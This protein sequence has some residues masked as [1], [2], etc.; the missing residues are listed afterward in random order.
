MGRYLAGRLAQAI[1][2]VLAIAAITFF[3]L[4]VAPGDPVRVMP[5]DQ[6]SEEAGQQVRRQMGLDKPLPEQFLG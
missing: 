5:G 3:V 4:N 6:A 1:G 2:V